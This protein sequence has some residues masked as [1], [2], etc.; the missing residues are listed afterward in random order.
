MTRARLRNGLG[1]PRAV[2]A[3]STLA[4]AVFLPWGIAAILALASSIF[5]PLLPLSAGLFADVLYYEPRAGAFPLFTLGG[6]AASA[7]AFIVRDRLRA[8]TIRE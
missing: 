3:F 5:E 6:G 4:A 7:L 1:A 8:G 2:L